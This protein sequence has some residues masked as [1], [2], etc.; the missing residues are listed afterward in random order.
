MKRAH[1]R[2]FS[3]KRQQAK[4]FSTILHTAA[5]ANRGFVLGCDTKCYGI[6]L[7]EARRMR[8]ARVALSYMGV[9][10]MHS[11]QSAIY[12]YILPSSEVFLTVVRRN[13]SDASW[14]CC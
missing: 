10:K 12:H 3:E 4:I 8:G 13:I 6:S 2:G 14:P 5:A 9:W 1:R 11:Q 7:C